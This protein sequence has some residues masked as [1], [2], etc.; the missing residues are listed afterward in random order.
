M[1]KYVCKQCKDLETTFRLIATHRQTDAHE[2]EQVVPPFSKFRQKTNL[3][4]LP[5]TYPLQLTGLGA[6]E[7]T[8]VLE[9]GFIFF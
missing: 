5:P 4:R 1:S 8:T 6:P 2:G 7:V 3:S 9:T